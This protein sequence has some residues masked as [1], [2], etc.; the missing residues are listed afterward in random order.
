MQMST[1]KCPDYEQLEKAARLVGVNYHHI[2]EMGCWWRTSHMSTSVYRWD[3]REQNEAA[4]QLANAIHAYDC[5]GPDGK[6]LRGINGE[7]D[8]VSLARVRRSIF[9]LAFTS[10]GK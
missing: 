10:H 7:T 5:I 3:P 1:K 9:E 4:I 6:T 2:D 8:D